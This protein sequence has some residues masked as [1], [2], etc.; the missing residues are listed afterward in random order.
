M[1]ERRG[2]R[3]ARIGGLLALG[4]LAVVGCRAGRDRGRAPV[5]VE[6]ALQPAA[7]APID[8][9]PGWSESGQPRRF[10]GKDLFN[11]ID[12][13]AEVFLEMGF[14]ELTVRTF[15]DGENTLTLEVYEMA[16][17]T[18]ARGIFLRFRGR[19]T[20]LAGIDGR[21]V[22]NR[23]QATVQR[24]RFFIQVSSA[25]GA[26]RCLPAMVSLVLQT[27]VVIP[28]DGDVEV[29][30]L[31]PSEGLV[32]GT[33]AIICGPY[34]LQNIFTLGAGDILQLEGQIC[35]VAGDY[36]SE[37]GGSITRLIVD[38]GCG[39]LAQA[40]FDHLAGNLDAHLQL[41]RQDEHE[42]VFRDHTGEFGSAVVVGGRLEISLHL[43]TAP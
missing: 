38:Y 2:R 33:E 19:G 41:V 40:A 11:H 30:S 43:P 27:L 3:A 8:A 20:P 15:S 39:D 35:G 31:L 25:S 32:A 21:N 28:E 18:A 14:R 17:P 22:G 23:Y 16:N 37:S 5:A 1:F 10:L 4:L 29:L 7:A 42:L 6:S 13:G 36:A 26:E 9:G 24:D 12:G 34:A